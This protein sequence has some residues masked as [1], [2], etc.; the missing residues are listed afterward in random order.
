MQLLNV[1]SRA[2]VSCRTGELRQWE[3]E[4]KAQALGYA[5]GSAAAEP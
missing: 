4:G 2:V 5:K 1:E 3:L